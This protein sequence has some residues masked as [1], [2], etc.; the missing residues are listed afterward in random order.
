M[1][2]NQYED[3]SLNNYK[4]SLMGLTASEAAFNMMARF[5]DMLENS[6]QQI[7]PMTQAFYDGKLEKMAFYL[8]QS[9][10]FS[11]K[12]L[13]DALNTAYRIAMENFNEDEI[14]LLSSSD[15]SEAVPVERT[16]WAPYPYYFPVVRNSNMS[17]GENFKPFPLQLREGDEIKTY[18]KGFGVGSPFKIIFQIPVSV[19]KYF[20][21]Q[22]GLHPKLG[23]GGS[24]IFKV[25]I[26][27]KEV[28]NSGVVS[29]PD[30]RDVKIELN[31][32]RRLT[33]AV[34]SPEETSKALN[35]QAVWA[36]PLLMKIGNSS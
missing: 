34:D 17:L 27:E 8:T 11:S 3:F 23:L 33:L 30:M 15:L 7:L 10:S 21:A 18:H 2:E 14:S 13:A 4:P 19:Y 32:A 16:A 6:I 5:T 12:V 20:S 25:F 28:Y 35:S 26:D 9:A 31:N 29:F 24:V 22:I 1:L 36:Y